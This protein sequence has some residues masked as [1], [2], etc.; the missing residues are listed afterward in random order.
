MS[1]T[2]ILFKELAEIHR[3]LPAPTPLPTCSACGG[4]MPHV[5][6]GDRH[7]G[8]KAAAADL[9]LKSTDSSLV[10][11]AVEEI[12]L[13]ITGR[14]RGLQQD[15]IRDLMVTTVSEGW[16][17]RKKAKARERSREKRQ[18]EKEKHQARR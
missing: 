1:V 8:C 13:T 9:E 14:L 11:V 16:E 7:A 2:S 4:K 17:E 12:G 18:R 10:R 5:Q 6:V 3:L 15:M